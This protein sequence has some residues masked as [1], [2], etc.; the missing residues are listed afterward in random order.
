MTNYARFF[1]VN[2][3]T[4]TRWFNELRDAGYLALDDNADS[5]NGNQ[6][7]WTYLVFPLP[8]SIFWNVMDID[9]ARE[10]ERLE[11]DEGIRIIHADFETYHKAA[12]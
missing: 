6:R 9:K 1:D 3:R 2:V 11:R 12:N 8:Q 5:E 10:I 7:V 4:I